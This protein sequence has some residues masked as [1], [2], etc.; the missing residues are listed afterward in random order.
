MVDALIKFNVMIIFSFEIDDYRN[1]RSSLLTCT[2]VCLPVSLSLS[3][4]CLPMSLCVSLSLCLSLSVVY[5]VETSFE[6]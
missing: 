3:V 4:L 5:K 1:R 6:R 2:E